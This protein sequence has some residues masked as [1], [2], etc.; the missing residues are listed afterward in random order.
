[1]ILRIE[2]RFGFSES[3]TYMVQ[4]KVFVINYG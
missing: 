4:K 2:G 1:M 3:D